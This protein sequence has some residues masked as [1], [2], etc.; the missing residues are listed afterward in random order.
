MLFCIRD[1]TAPSSGQKEISRR[2]DQRSLPFGGNSWREPLPPLGRVA[3][4]KIVAVT[5][6]KISRTQARRAA[7]A[8]QTSTLSLNRL[9]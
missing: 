3:R 5:G 2:A 7:A 4:Q 1:Y 8:N 6:K 9:I